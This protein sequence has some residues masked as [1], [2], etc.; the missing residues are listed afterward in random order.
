[1]R[2]GLTRSAVRTC[3]GKSMDA[4]RIVTDRGSSDGLKMSMVCQINDLRRFREFL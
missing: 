4:E 1:M 3:Y 2:T